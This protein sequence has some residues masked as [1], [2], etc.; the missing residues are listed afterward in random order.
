MRIRSQLVVLFAFVFAAALAG[1]AG[2]LKS[3]PGTITTVILI[4]HAER[5]HL[6][7]DLDED[8]RIR[9]AALPAAV[10]D[11][12]IAAIYSPNLQRNLNTIRPLAEQ[13]G[14]EIVIADPMSAPERMIAGHP[15]QIVLWVGNTTNLGNIMG[16]LGGEGEPPNTYGDLYILT[17]PDDGP[18]TIAKRHFGR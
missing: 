16:R 14:I 1:C 9:A 15:G 6:S 4:R 8:G 18:T 17:I 2:P 3:P 11:L 10:A 7:D 13:R 5:L 12:D